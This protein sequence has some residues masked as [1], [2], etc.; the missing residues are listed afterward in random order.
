[1]WLGVI[2]IFRDHGYRRLRTKARLKFLM[3]EWG[4]ERFR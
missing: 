2:S 1:M 3:A 4:P